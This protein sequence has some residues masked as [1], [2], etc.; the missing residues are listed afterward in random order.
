MIFNL[1]KDLAILVQQQG[2]AID[3]IE[4][5]IDDAHNYVVGAEQELIE[6]KDLH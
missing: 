3:N 5:N 1:F 4:L 6:A 2:E